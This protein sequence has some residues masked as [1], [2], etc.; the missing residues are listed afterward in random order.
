[1]NDSSE[2]KLHFLDYWRVIKVRWA[3]VTITFLLVMISAAVTCYFLPREYYSKVTM[4]VKS[5]DTKLAIFGGNSGIR[6]TDQ[7]KLTPTQYQIIQRKEILYP[8]IENLKLAE[9][10][11]PV[12]GQ[13]IP[14]EQV[15]ETLVQK[16]DLREVRNTDL[17]EIGVWSTDRQEAA[18]IANMVAIVYQDK[19]KSDQQ[20]M[21]N[22][23][24]GQLQEEVDKQRK[25][26]QDAQADAAKIRS[27]EGIIDP[28]PESL[29]INDFGA[30]NTVRSDEQQVNDIKVKIAELRTTLQ[31]IEKLTPEELTS[32]LHSLGLEDPTVSKVL[33]LYQEAFAED[34]RLANSGL[35]ENHPK[36]KSLRAQKAVYFTQL[37][38]QIAALRNSYAT[39]LK[40]SEETLK[41][42]QDKLS[43]SR[44]EWQ[45]SRKK[46][47]S[48]LNA[49]NKYVAARHVLDAAESRLVTERMQMQMGLFPA[50]IW[51]KAEPALG[52][53]KP[54]VALYMSI[55]VMVGIGFGMALAFFIEY[56]DTS[57]KTLEDVERLLAVPV[58]AVVPKGVSAL[59]KNNGDSP[60]AEAYRIMQTNLEFNK[61]NATANTITLVSGGPGE[62]KS[63]TLN[64]LA[65]TCAKGGYRVLI[66]DA[67]LRRPTQH[68]FFEMDN[69]VGLSDCLTGEKEMSEVIL[70]TSIPNLSFM[71][72]GKLPTDAVGILNSQ[73]MSDLIA[74]AKSRFDL[75][76]FDSPPILGVSD[77]SIL[78]SEV[79]ITI[80]VVQYRRFPRDMLVRVKQAILQVGGNLLGAVLNSVD[81]K[82][83]SGYQYYTQYYDY[84]TAQPSEKQKPRKRRDAQPTGQ[85]STMRSRNNLPHGDY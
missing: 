51:E 70:S 65:I 45:D 19:R 22:Q 34:A 81:T 3:I 68:L 79:D 21:M 6:G 56:L 39:K 20:A 72:S 35:G 69:S 25:A 17:I 36:V 29:D 75:V 83:D 28:N 43:T 85:D 31:G 33:P 30:Q 13:R 9:T 15:Y 64:N 46:S 37:N 18:N 54:N 4:E 80:M 10:W 58:L 76:F 60:D 84:Y 11:G 23:G 62:G 12:P 48:Y 61:K 52:P 53:G 32:A 73:K 66:V 59:I 44:N 26:V 40:V 55:A 67:D 49:K 5:D 8:V 47:A 71:P 41:A 27:E 7:Q 77:A 38:Q 57:V 82:H 1:M 16:M 78:S 63:T 42:L 74:Q 50:K 24:L 14:R 2:V